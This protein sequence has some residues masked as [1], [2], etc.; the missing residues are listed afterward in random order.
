MSAPLTLETPDVVQRAPLVVEIELAHGRVPAWLATC[1]GELEREGVISVVAHEAVHAPARAREGLGAT[2]DAWIARR[3]LPEDDRALTPVPWVRPRA[4]GPAALVLQ[5]TD[6]APRTFHGTSWTLRFGASGTF[7]RDEHARGDRVLA[8]ELLARA[9]PGEPATTFAETRTKAAHSLA[10]SRSNAGWKAASLLERA[11]R[12]HA[13]GSARA[14]APHSTTFVMPARPLLAP[15]SATPRARPVRGPLVRTLARAV[16]RITHEDAWQLAWRTRLPDDQL[17]ADTRWTAEHV[18]AAPR[19]RFYADP[20]LLEHAGR[21]ALFFEEYDAHAGRGHIAAVELDANGATGPVRRVADAAHHLSY[22]FV[23]EHE[24]AAYMIPETSAARR[25][26]LW[27]ARAFPFEWERVSVLLDGLRA[28]D[29]TWCAHAGRFWLFAC[30]A[31]AHAPLSEELCAFWSERPFGPWQPHA[32]N[33]IV[34]D[35]CGARPAG[36]LFTDAGRLVRPA[37]DVSREY[38]GR[39]VFHDVLELTP[40]RYT[41]RTLGA[42]EPSALAARSCS[43]ASGVHT[44]DR[45]A[46][47]E[48]VDVRETRWKRP[49]AGLWSGA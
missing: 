23:F 4:H 20:F 32:L 27:R 45:S 12:R 1:L 42:L 25:V 2:L 9:A 13:A 21:E 34:D 14:H 40:R 3:I 43:G 24:G 7:Y 16:A 47:H 48:V 5:W 39:I 11:L 49:L 28:V 6:E 41:E 19:G 33:P 26:E 44:F 8:I 17:P 37:Q 18:L 36:R 35:P 29:T 22:P 15:P 31:R 46:R 30:V 10:L 38:G